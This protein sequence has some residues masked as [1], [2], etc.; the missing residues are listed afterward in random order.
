MP[1]L[2]GRKASGCF[3]LGCGKG[4][5]DRK[6]NCCIRVV[7]SFDLNGMEVSER[8]TSFPLDANTDARSEK[9]EGKDKAK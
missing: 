3:F 5:F 4:A 8:I 9:P 6:V 2:T 1:Y 7:N